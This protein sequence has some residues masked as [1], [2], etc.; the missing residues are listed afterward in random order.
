MDNNFVPDGN[1]ASESVD[2]P[3][4]NASVEGKLANQTELPDKP[5]VFRRLLYGADGLRAGWSVLLFLLI[6]S[7]VAIAATTLVRRVYPLKQPI[8]GTEFSPSFTLITEGIPLAVVVFAAWV[9]SRIE[10]RSFF[11]YGLDW[12]PRRL[13]HFVVGWLWGALLLSLLVGTLWITG[14]LVFTGM[15][16]TGVDILLWG[17]IWLL[18]FLCVSLFEEFLTRG[19]LQFTLTRG[20]AGLAGALGMK[21]RSRKVLGFWIAALFFSFV[22]GLGHRNN[23]GESPLGLLSAGLIGLVFAFSLW[24]TG[25][26]WWAIGYHAAWDW[27]E[28]FLYG[29]RDS[30]MLV[31]HHLLASHPQGPALMSGGLTGPEGSIFILG[32]C[33]L[34]AIV[35]ALTLRPEPGSPSDPA[36]MPGRRNS[37]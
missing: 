26:L 18:S 37:I 10:K 8:A 1:A 16:L 36:A 30:G 24:R 13:R 29:V 3:A 35:V 20:F 5:S 32:G 33:I 15:L 2:S 25:S 22:F 34:T 28:S 31:Q 12:S 7:L 14:F 19:F 9:V 21:E 17:I 4:L 23:A 6:A 11:R 27:A